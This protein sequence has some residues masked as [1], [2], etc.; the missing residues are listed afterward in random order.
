MHKAIGLE[1]A[2]A[3]IPDGASLMIGGFMG[4]GSPI[5]LIA[6]LVRQGRKGLTVIANGA[7]DASC[8]DIG[9]DGELKNSRGRYADS[10]SRTRRGV[11]DRVNGVFADL[12]T[13]KVDGRMVITF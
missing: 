10:G 13:G 7:G 11:G 8:G 3:K 6:E 1:A 9:S 5:R 2:V 12:K 4:V